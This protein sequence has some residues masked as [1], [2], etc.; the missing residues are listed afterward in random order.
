MKNI[1]VGNGINIQYDNTNYAPRNIVL[2]MLLSFDD[3]NYP[4]DYIVDDPMLLK[5]YMGKLFLAAREAIDGKFDNYTNCTTERD[6]LKDF[7]QRYV[8]KKKSLR[9]TDI[10]FEDYYLIH[11]LLCHKVRIFNPE[12]FTIRESLKMAYF[13]SIYNN[14]KLNLLYKQYDKGLITFL[15]SFDS[16]FTTNYDSNLESAT[17]KEVYH[18][19]GQFDRLSETY[20]PNSFRNTLSDNAI[21]GIPNEPQYQYLHSTALSTYCGDYKKYQLKENILANEAIEK[22]AHGYQTM[23]VAKKDI[24]SWEHE[25]NQVLVNL[26]E[27]I[28]LKAANPNLHFQEDYCIKEFQAI[29]DELVILGLSPY[30]DCHL[31]EMINNASLTKCTFY[32][33]EESECNRIKLLLSKVNKEKNLQFKNVKEFWEGL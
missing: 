22:M 7:K 17:G 12:Q 5:N 20:N 33:Y 23:E 4:C 3:E 21:E 1:L 19:H 26:G 14:G 16:I 25:S 29:T 6:G 11:D 30:N 15:S 8:D 24:D 13:H 9:I 2:R 28:K 27:A 32:Y 31:F 10:G 18:I